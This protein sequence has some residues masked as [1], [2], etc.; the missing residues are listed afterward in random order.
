MTQEL[1]SKAW[2]YSIEINVTK[3]DK[4]GKRDVYGKIKANG[5]DQAE[6]KDAVSIA[7]KELI[8]NLNE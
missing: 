1:P 5:D 2:K 6:F 7:V 4:Q 3:P 8:D